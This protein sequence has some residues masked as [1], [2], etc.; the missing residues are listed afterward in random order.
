MAGLK[1]LAKALSKQGKP[2]GRKKTTNERKREALKKGKTSQ[3]KKPKIPK[4]AAGGSGKLPPNGRSKKGK[5]GYTPESFDMIELSMEEL[6]GLY[7]PISDPLGG[8]TIRRKKP[9][10]KGWGKARK[11]KG[12]K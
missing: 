4:A 1:A 2:K 7:G 10:T 12:G 5:R 3:V 6:P 11:P 9:V 8:R